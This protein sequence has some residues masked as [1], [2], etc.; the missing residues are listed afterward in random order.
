MSK[1]GMTKEEYEIWSKSDP[2]E[3]VDGWVEYSWEHGVVGVS[4]CFFPNEKVAK[5]YFA[6]HGIVNYYQE[7]V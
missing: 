2:W 1:Y 6:A 7:T 4:Y 3:P 5:A